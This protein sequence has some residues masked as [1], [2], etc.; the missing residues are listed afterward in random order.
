M[1][2]SRSLPTQRDP[3]TAPP[4]AGPSE[5]H[6][7]ATTKSRSTPKI[8]VVLPIRNEAATIEA[9]LDGLR[10]QDV[11]DDGVEI[12][13]VDGMSSDATRPRVEAYAK[14]HPRPHIRVID[15]PD[16]IVPTA[17]NAGIRAARGDVI[18][19]MD[20]HT[21]PAN[22]YLARCVDALE[23]TGAGNVGGCLSPRSQGTFGQAVALA[24]A[25]PLGAGG[26]AFHGASEAQ[27]TDTV[28]LGAFPRSV[29][30]DVGGFDE[31]MR[32]NQDYEFNVRLRDAGYTVHLDPSIRSAYTPRETPA[33]L[34]RQYL[35]YGWW[36]VAT[37]RRH[38]TSLRVRQTIP[39]VFV[40]ALVV[41]TVAAPILSV[42][43]WV[44]AALLA[45]YALAL[46][47]GTLDVV[48]RSEVAL[49]VVASL[50]LAF[51]I[52][53]VAWGAGFLLAWFTRG[54]FPYGPSGPPRI[55]RIEGDSP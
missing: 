20:G 18:V 11:P 43:A 35:Q 33:A 12:L 47:V 40:A 52:I 30:E 26:A 50:P 10:A 6:A 1:T 9:C 27:D 2:S 38:P 31:T 14:R 46:A 53:H 39:P 3:E 41:T 48:R 24:Q 29:F 17:L 32:R 5:V 54:R 25:H 15:N 13:V 51:A 45:S 22:D 28:Y 49:P 8:S 34:W 23:R 55:P 36:R 7:S 4:D 21:V 44:W 42:A 37:V 16:R 19:R